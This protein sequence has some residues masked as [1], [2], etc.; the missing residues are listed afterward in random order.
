LL[1]SLLKDVSIAP[2]HRATPPKRPASALRRAPSS[3]AKPT[4]TNKR[5]TPLV[6]TPSTGTRS[7]ARRSASKAVDYS[8]DLVSDGDFGEADYADGFS[9]DATDEDDDDEDDDAGESEGRK[10]KAKPL[11]KAKSLSGHRPD[12]KVRTCPASVWITP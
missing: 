4:P 11:R 1:Q 2:V 7:S 9:D 6:R 10:R 5:L 12:P 8:D 3:S